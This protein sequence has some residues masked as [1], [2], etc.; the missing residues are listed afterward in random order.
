[1]NLREGFYA[2]KAEV[3]VLPKRDINYR[4]KL[5]SNDDCKKGLNFSGP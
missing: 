4:L 2:M 1:M 5:V 3:V